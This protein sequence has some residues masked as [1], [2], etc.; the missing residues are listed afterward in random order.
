MLQKTTPN[1]A[2][3]SLTMIFPKVLHKHCT[4]EQY[5]FIKRRKFCGALLS[6]HQWLEDADT[7]C[8]HS[9]KRKGEEMPQ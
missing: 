5:N 6:L 2:N 4:W 1:T 3:I 8:L 7:S 9:W